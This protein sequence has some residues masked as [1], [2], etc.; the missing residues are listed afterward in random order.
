MH[1]APVLTQKNKVTVGYYR[2]VYFATLQVGGACV[3]F[4]Y[5][6]KNGM[7]TQQGQTVVYTYFVVGEAILSFIFY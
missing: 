4:S 5:R 2:L 7:T 3:D 1:N 6:W